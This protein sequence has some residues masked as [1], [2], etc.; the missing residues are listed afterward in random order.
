MKK[1]SPV[2]L[3]LAG[4]LLLSSCASSLNGKYQKVLLY[5]NSPEAK[6][7]I[8]NEQSGKGKL[9]QGKVKRDLNVHQ[10]KVEAPGYKP[11]YIV[12]F[13]QKKSP[14]Y[15]MSWIPF[16]ILLYPPLLDRGPKSWN[17]EKEY[18]VNTKLKINRRSNDQKYIYLKSTAFDVKKED[19]VVEEFSHRRFTKNKKSRDITTSKTEVKI[20]NSI[21]TDAIND[22]LK[23][24][25][26][27]DTTNSVL[28]NKTNTMYL[29][30]RVSKVTFKGVSA[31]L[32]YSGGAYCVAE[33][34]VEWD[35]LDI[36]EQSK[37]KKTITT[38]SGEFAANRGSDNNF[39]IS[40]VEDALTT[41]FIQFI[42]DS[43]V[44][45]LLNVDKAKKNTFTKLKVT[46]KNAGQQT[47]KN[48]QAATVTI[49]TKDGHG[50]G[51]IIS[52]AGY[53]VTNY[54]VVAGQKEMTVILNSGD[55][56]KAALVRANEESDLALLMIDAVPANLSAFTLPAASNFEVGDE[57]FAI[58]T[59]KSIELSQTLSKGII[60]GLRKLPDSGKLIQTDVSVNAGN[61]GGALVTKGGELVGIVNSKLVGF[62]VEGI[63]FCIPANAISE[64]LA[65][66]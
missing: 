34:A 54:H 21:F 59:P 5:T 7:Y 11:E 9:V 33:I 13:Q 10:F 66:E 12:A 43:S 22:I 57:V 46:S 63:S 15:I 64:I 1:T 55:E 28:K 27:A 32:A 53:I 30:A 50:S 42:D 3:L 65:L 37:V 14:L 17:Y 51:C 16:G 18:T 56:Y 61:S 41:S 29:K 24:Y 2:S 49:K 23:D 52:N 47:L 60:S 36:Y 4:A 48:A 6:V 31:P 25:D 40:S 20:D 35:L 44:K 45:N 58:G 62:G 19:L 38:R 26:F 39:I 8:D